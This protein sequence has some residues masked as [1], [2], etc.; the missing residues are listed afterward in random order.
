MLAGLDHA[1]EVIARLSVEVERQ[2]SPFAPA[3]ELLCSMPGAARRT[4]EVIV[5]ETGGDVSTC[6]PSGPI[7]TTPTDAWSST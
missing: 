5:A 2:I 3:I 4:A 7:R 6:W 1:D